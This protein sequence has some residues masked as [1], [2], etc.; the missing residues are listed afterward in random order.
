MA[1][2]ERSHPLA[3]TDDVI[4]VDLPDEVLIQVQARRR[5][6]CLNPTAAFVWRQCDGKATVSAIARRL[7]MH[8]GAPPDEAVVELAI[9]ELRRARLLVEPA[10]RRADGPRLNRREALKRAGLAAAVALPLVTS[11]TVPTAS[12]AASCLPNGAP[13]STHSECCS[14]VCSSSLCVPSVPSDRYIKEHFAPVDPQGILARVAALPIES[15]NYKG[16]D[17]RVRHIGPMAQDFAAA[18]A[19]GHDDRHIHVIDASGV[20]LA[21]IQGLHR[22]VAAQAAELRTLSRELT[23][24]RTE[25]GALRARDGI[26]GRGDRRTGGREAAARGLGGGDVLQARGPVAAAAA[27]PR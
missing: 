10:A 20:A 7:G 15:W 2:P 27:V 14:L 24:L 21:A 12:M 19:V 11:I 13:C 22:L 17:P 18:F 1:T 8:T 26:L 5:A 23:A 6:H 9:A 3:R 4:V 16:Q 25:R